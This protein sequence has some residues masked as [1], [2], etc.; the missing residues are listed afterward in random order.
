MLPA[1]R[2]MEV[3]TTA[4]ISDIVSEAILVAVTW[5]HTY[6]MG[7]LPDGSHMKTP[8]ATSLVRNGQ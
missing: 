1:S 6:R 4:D 7:R 8:L 5:R 3:N 2:A